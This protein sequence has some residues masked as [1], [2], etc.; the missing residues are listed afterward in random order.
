MAG[1]RKSGETIIAQ[2]SGP[3]ADARFGEVEQGEVKGRSTNILSLA[4]EDGEGVVVLF[5]DMERVSVLCAAEHMSDIADRMGCNPYDVPSRTVRPHRQGGGLA[6]PLSSAYSPRRL[7][8]P[9]DSV[10][11]LT[12]DK[13]PG[14]IVAH[15]DEGTGRVAL[16]ARNSFGGGDSDD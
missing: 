9:A 10:K 3:C 8:K 6:L 1:V 7:L 16:Y 14:F 5:Y 12:N 15:N 13:N 4:L 11:F 2:A